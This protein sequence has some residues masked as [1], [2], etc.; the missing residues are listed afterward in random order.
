MRTQLTFE[1]ESQADVAADRVANKFPSRPNSAMQEDTVKFL[2]LEDK[3]RRE[4][5][6]DGQQAAE[7][8]AKLQKVCASQAA[9]D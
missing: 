8:F 7:D 1:T 4:E 6:E 5:P 2:E 3:I 9:D